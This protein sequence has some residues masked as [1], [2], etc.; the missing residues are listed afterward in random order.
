VRF[1][2]TQQKELLARLHRLADGNADLVDEAIRDAAKR[3]D[4]G[5]P[6]LGA[7]IRYI[8]DKT[9]TSEQSHTAA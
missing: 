8:L 9:R 4:P 1:M 3:A 6:E 2:S 5:Q 7:V